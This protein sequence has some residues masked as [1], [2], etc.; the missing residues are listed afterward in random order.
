MRA[1]AAER[2]A[3]IVSAARHVFVSHGDEV[4]LDVVAHQA[5]VGIATL[6]RNFATREQ[7]TQE[8]TRSILADIQSVAQQT[9]TALPSQGEEAWHQCVHALV[10]LEI[11]ALS[12]ALAR[13]ESGDLPED[14]REFQQEVLAD[15]E[16]LLKIATD[17]G[18]VRTNISALE[19]VLL[20]GL[21]IE[22]K[23]HAVRDLV[24]NFL[25]TVTKVVL[26]GLSGKPQ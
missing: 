13:Y 22:P 1:D 23:S 25:D 26:E 5:G 20:I 17:Q 9:T 11:G 10:K 6:Y 8:V 19:L 18:L 14:L 4:A 21:I 24:P 15:V 7:L 3:K 2:R 16:Q 12:S